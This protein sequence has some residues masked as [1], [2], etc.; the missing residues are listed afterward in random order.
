MKEIPTVFTPEN[1]ASLWDFGLYAIGLAFSKN[2]RHITADGWVRDHGGDS[3]AEIGMPLCQLHHTKNTSDEE[4]SRD[5]AF[6]PDIGEAHKEYREWKRQSSHMS[7][8]SG[9]RVDSR[10]SPFAK[11]V[12]KHRDKSRRDERYWAGTEDIDRHYKQ[13]MQ[14]KATSYIAKHPKDRKP[15]KKR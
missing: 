5:F 13:K 15:V 1:V 8:I 3:D 11:A 7:A 6:H 12:A 14:D 9:K 4:H 2:V 10:N